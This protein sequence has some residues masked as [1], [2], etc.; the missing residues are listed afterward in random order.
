QAK[1]EFISIASHQLRT[2]LTVIKGYISM[3][4]EGSFGKVPEVIMENLDKVYISN[5]RLITL[6]EDLLNISRI[7]SGRQEFLWKQ[8]NMEDLAKTVVENLKQT[9]KRKDLKL[10][11]HSPGK[12]TPKVT[13]DEGKI[14]E[15]MMNFVDNAIK[16]TD[17]GEINVY[18]N[19]EPQKEAVTFCVKDTGKGISKDG[20]QMLF[21]KFS[22]GKGSFR[23][24]TEGLG[25]G[26]YVAKMMLDSHQGKIWAESD[27]EG[28]G[29]KFCFSLS[30]KLTQKELEKVLPGKKFG[31]K[32]KAKKA[33]GV[34]SGK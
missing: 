7:E 6:V 2:P 27:G 31:E 20:L 5:E 3:M 1:S 30:T 17:E 9:A 19:Y 4:K 8:I 10:F 26:L 16:Y 22:R 28:K 21:K 34:K 13:A 14:H 18:I 25:L 11:F 32:V 33:S 29:S 12:T 24:H 23:A 15:V